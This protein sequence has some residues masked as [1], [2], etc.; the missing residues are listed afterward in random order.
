MINLFNNNV[1]SHF[2]EILKKRQNQVSLDRF[3]VKVARKEKDSIDPTDS[4]DYISDSESHPI[5]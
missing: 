5:L 2:H 1:M 4:S 3:L